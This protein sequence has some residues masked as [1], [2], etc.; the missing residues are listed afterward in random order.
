MTS[1]VK[2]FQI[3]IPNIDNNQPI[4]IQFTSYGDNKEPEVIWTPPP[5]DTKELLLICYD[6]DA[7]AHTWI[8]WLVS[9]VPNNGKYGKVVL[10]NDNGHNRY[11]G[12]R[13]PAGT[14]VHHYYF[15]VFALDIH[16]NLD[17]NKQ[18]SYP[19]I[20]RMIKGHVI[21]DSTI[22]GTYKVD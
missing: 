4:N 8:H 1:V 7:T 20:M 2:T 18:Y 9:I 11:D 19:E 21:T 17:K 15:R 6:P 22:I 5:R 3:K 14:G 10:K 16:M 12:P 13:P